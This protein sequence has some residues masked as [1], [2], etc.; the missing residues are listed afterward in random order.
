MSEPR[1]M[2]WRKQ[3]AAILSYYP[4]AHKINGDQ[5]ESAVWSAI[6]E[7]LGPR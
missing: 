4:E 2:D 7:V 1:L 6:Q 3:E 5:S